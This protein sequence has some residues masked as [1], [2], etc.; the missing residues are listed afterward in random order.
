MRLGELN[1]SLVKTLV[2]G[3]S[4]VEEVAIGEVSLQITLGTSPLTQTH[5]I[6]FLVMDTPSTYN[7][8]LG[9]PTLNKFE[10]ILSTVHMKLK[11]P[12]GREV[13]EVRGDQEDS[14]RCYADGVRV[15]SK[16]RGEI[17]HSLQ[18]VQRTV[19]T[20]NKKPRVTPM[21]ELLTIELWPQTPVC[22]TR[23]DSEMSGEV[24]RE[25]IAFLQEN[26]DV[27]SW[28]PRDL[29]GIDPKFVQHRLNIRTDTRPIKQKRRHFGA[30]KDGIIAAEVE[31]LLQAGHVKEIQ[32]PNW[33]SNVVLVKKAEGKWRMCIDFRDINKACPKDHYPLPRIDQL[34]DSTAGYE[35]LSMMD[36]SQGY[37]QIMLHPDDH[38]NVSFVTAAD[39]FCYVVMPYGLKNVG[40][41]YQ[42]LVD[43]MFR[44]QLGRNMEVYVDDMLVKS[45]EARTHIEDLRETFAKLRQYEMKLNPA[46]CSFGVRAGNFLGYMVTERGIEVNPEKVQAVLG[47]RSPRTVKEVQVLT[48][49][50]AA[51]GRFISGS[52]ARSLPF[53][54]VL[55]KNKSFV[56]TAECQLAFDQLKAYL[57]QVPLLPKPIKNESLLLYVAAG[58]GV[59]SSVLGAEQR[60]SDIE[61]IAYA[62]MISAQKL[63]PYFLS[64]AII[65]RTNYHLK[66]ILSNP[67]VSGRM[68][69]WAV[70]LGQYD[71][72]FQPRVAI[73]EQVLADFIQETTPGCGE[74]EGEVWEAHV[75]GSS[76]IGG[77][78]VGIVLTSAKGEVSEYAVR[79]AFRAS[80]NE[81]EYEAIKEGLM[82]AWARRVRF[83]RVFSD[84]QLIVQQIKGAFDVKDE[85]MGRYVAQIFKL[86]AQFDHCKVTQ[87]PR[88]ENRRADFLARMASSAAGVRERSISLRVETECDAKAKVLSIEVK[89]DWRQPLL[90]FLRGEK[91]SGRKEQDKMHEGC[92]GNH[93]GAK[94][95]AKRLLQA[96]YFWPPMKKDSGDL[97]KRCSKCQRHAPLIHVPAEELGIMTSPSPFSQWGIDIVGPFPVASGRSHPQANGQVEVTN[98]IIVSGIKKRLEEAKGAWTEELAVLWA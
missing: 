97:V 66:Q 58:Q 52:A 46:K 79:L 61:K 41:T 85:R 70:E 14:R 19:D 42:R 92:C 98:R 91:V 26:H 73:K 89:K 95:L 86:M 65:V 8:I 31:R 51:L 78:G 12:V 90:A 36:A 48:G 57:V 43:T 68:V 60:Y 81:A 30:E 64:H 38:K 3:F 24:C 22:T 18:E 21:E 67:E 56:W 83:I 2:Y 71:V 6:R 23:I 10:A 32:F 62:I 54:E 49:R 37:H 39:T 5:I 72:E 96:G 63:K 25:L 29:K 40:A 28:G 33:L 53:F 27:F 34:V 50:M 44:S 16:K 15:A 1:V 75:D 80:N 94:S 13:G 59:V 93:T 84:S 4:G 87:I 17:V 35:L 9:R 55:K 74:V 88:E 20:D 76:I 47:M 11:F 82:L 69:K 7:V 77:C 45:K